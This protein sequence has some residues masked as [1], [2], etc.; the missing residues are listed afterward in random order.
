MIY[1]I[2]TKDGPNEI[3][4]IEDDEVDVPYIFGYR[5]FEEDNRD[6][7]Y[8]FIHKIFPYFRI[9]YVYIS[10]I[11]EYISIKLKIEIIFCIFILILLVLGII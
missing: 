11:H 3:I 8:N 10:T 1:M 4:F 2:Y 9:V 5:T 7:S 6:K